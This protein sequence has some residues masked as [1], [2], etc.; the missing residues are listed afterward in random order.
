MEIL[1]NDLA[2]RLYLAKHRKPDGS[3]SKPTRN[4]ALRACYHFL[5]FTNRPITDH[6]M[7]DLIQAKKANPS[8]RTLEDD[9]T[10]FRPEHEQN[11]TA[12]LLGICHK[13]YAK[14]ELSI[15]IRSRGKTVP[16]KEGILLAIYNDPSLTQEHRD[17]M[18]LMAYVAERITACTKLPPSRIR[19]IDGTNYA[20][21]DIPSGLAKTGLEHPSII[22]RD[23]AE[24]LLQRAQEHGYTVLFPNAVTRWVQISKLAREKYHVVLTSRYFRKRFESKAEPIQQDKMNC[25]HWM[26]LMGS[27]GKLGHLP[28]IYGLKFE[29]KIIKEYHQFLYPRL[30]LT[31]SDEDAPIQDDKDK[32]IEQLIEQNKKLTATLDKILLKLGELP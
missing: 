24:R 23:L 8:D 10:L 20:I 18:L 29:E 3:V 30:T 4:A 11:L 26:Y 14:V 16:I 17:A 12:Y 28:D 31:G 32:L 21:L 6:A 15:H 7:Y 1:A 2:F 25:N 9:I 22:P 19:L 5:N 27:K 13:N